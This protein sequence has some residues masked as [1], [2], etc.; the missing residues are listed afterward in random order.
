MT[1]ETQTFAEMSFIKSQAKPHQIY[2]PSSDLV[3]LSNAL[4]YLS[5]RDCESLA[6]ILLDR[7]ERRRFLL[8]YEDALVAYERAPISNWWLASQ[9]TEIGRVRTATRILISQRNWHPEQI[10]DAMMTVSHDV[11]PHPLI[12][13]K[14]VEAGIRDGLSILKERNRAIESS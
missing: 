14:A 7:V 11:C 1:I 4:N 12:A 10:R 5:A 13:A 8:T 6:R 3:D 9:F 2:Q